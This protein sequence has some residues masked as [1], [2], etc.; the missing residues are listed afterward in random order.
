M[1]IPALRKQEMFVDSKLI[2]G[3]KQDGLN[4]IIASAQHVNLRF[5]LFFIMVQFDDDA[6]F[7]NASFFEPAFRL[8]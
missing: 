2:P 1:A 7:I 6:D 3:L 8:T 4:N 5:L